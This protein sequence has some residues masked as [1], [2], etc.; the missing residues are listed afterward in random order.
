[1]NILEA[2]EVLE[3]EKESGFT[4]ISYDIEDAVDLAIEALK[5]VHAGR[6]QPP[7]LAFEPLP[8]ETP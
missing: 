6:P 2:I 7:S 1:M 3:I 8:G 4:R 5:R